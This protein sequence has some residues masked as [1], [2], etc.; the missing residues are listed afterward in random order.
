MANKLWKLSFI[1]L[2][3]IKQQIKIHIN[4]SWAK[5]FDYNYWHFKRIQNLTQLYFFIN[6]Y[7][8]FGTKIIKRTWATFFSTN[9]F[10]FC[11]TKTL[12]P[13]LGFCT[14]HTGDTKS[15]NENENLN[16][17]Y[18][19]Q[20][21]DVSLSLVFPNQNILNLKNDLAQPDTWKWVIKI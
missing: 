17:K 3:A 14:A 20:I 5:K 16:C 8:D 2:T 4:L 18:K 15:T 7:L 1:S 9:L 19:V 10:S 11:I 12:L 21:I 6:F 13:R